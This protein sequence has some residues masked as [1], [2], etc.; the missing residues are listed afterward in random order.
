MCEVLQVL[1]AYRESCIVVSMA[2][3]AHLMTTGILGVSLTFLEP[4]TS[5]S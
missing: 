2:S 4:S 3:V 5:P 1:P